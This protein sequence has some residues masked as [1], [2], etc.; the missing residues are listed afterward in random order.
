MQGA[1]KIEDRK[2]QAEEIQKGDIVYH[3]LSN[4]LFK[5]MDTKQQRWMNMNPFYVKTELKTIDYEQLAV[6]FS[7]IFIK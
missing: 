4:L 7:N 1:V 3:K 2:R 5:C 6:S